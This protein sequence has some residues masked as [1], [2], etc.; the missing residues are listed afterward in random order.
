MIRI[1]A[2]AAALA[3]ALPGC[4]NG[5]PAEARR[6]GPPAT[7]IT[8]TEAQRV[9]LEF[10][11][12]SVGTLENFIDPK[13]GAE[14][15]GRVVRVLGYVGK[16]V[17][18]GDL[19]AEIDS[20][21]FV[22]QNRSDEAEIKR[23]ESLVEQADRLVERQGRLQKQGFISQNAVDDATAQRNAQ[24]EQLTSARARSDGSRN[25]IRKARVVSPIDGRIEAQ[26]VAA[27]DYVKVGDPL[28]QMVGVLRLHAHLPFPEGASQR[29]R[30]GLPVRLS[31]PVIPGKVINAKIDE[32]RPTITQTSRAID[33]IVK[34][35]TDGSFRGGGTVNAQVV[36][37]VKENAVMV[38]EQS[39]VL[40]PA[41]KIVYLVQDG[42]AQQ[43]QVETGYK[44]RG[45][46]EIVSG[47]EGGELI[48]MDGA[49]FLTHNAAVTVP[50]PRAA[51]ADEPSPGGQAAKASKSAIEP[52]QKKGQRT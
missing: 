44:S 42:R 52:E 48:A 16:T 13:I 38:P 4:N 15:A 6:A 35:D 49:G 37:A 28:F 3:L 33:A 30:V 20:Q 41:G 12:E 18:Q 14:V 34:F 40:R 36:V 19:L 2:L 23:L 21:D 26:I 7:L 51:K 11:E 45:L 47:L 1:S 46:V 17:K 10:T 50:R 24:R 29:I 27:G 43:R 22:I 25:S 5:S 32:I 8:V 9:R 39:I 31:S